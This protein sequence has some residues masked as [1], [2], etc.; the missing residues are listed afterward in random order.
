MRVIIN[1]HSPVNT[2]STVTIAKE[3]VSNVSLHV[4]GVQPAVAF[5]LGQGKYVSAC[6]LA[7]VPYTQTLPE[8]IYFGKIKHRRQNCQ[9]PVL[10]E[11]FRKRSRA[12]QE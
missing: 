1:I 8:N 6:T 11:R 2:Q 9:D 4:P 3:N 12:L 5:T 7:H 10:L